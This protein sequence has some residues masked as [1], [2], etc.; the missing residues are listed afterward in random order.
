MSSLLIKVA[1]CLAMLCVGAAFLAASMPP[2]PRDANDN[3]AIYSLSSAESKAQPASDRSKSKARKIELKRFPAGPIA[4]RNYKQAI[5]PI[6]GNQSKLL[7]GWTFNFDN[8]IVTPD[9]EVITRITEGNVAAFKWE[10]EKR[11]ARKRG[12]YIV[13]ATLPKTRPGVVAAPLWLYSEGA[14]EGAHE[15]DFE[16][17]NGRIEYNLHNGNGGFNMRRVNKDLGGHRVRFEI[18]RRPNKVTM[19][20]ESLTDGFKDEL[21]VNP[22]KVRKWAKEPGAPKK[23]RWPPNRMAMF[24]V[25]EF[26]VSNSA[27][28]A[29]EWQPLSSGE[30]IEM[31]MHGYSFTEK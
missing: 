6:E 4:F 9:A 23:L 15:F 26:W 30:S 21:V 3:A 12:R 7:P 8:V 11:K 22:R 19:R 13:E 1:A 18:E 16:L 5:H 17:M 2:S 25:M 28:W 27:D 24:P 14:R 20:V 10:L 29:G 31:T